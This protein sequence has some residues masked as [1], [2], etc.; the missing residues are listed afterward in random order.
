MAL[1]GEA[2]TSVSLRIPKHMPLPT[3]NNRGSDIRIRRIRP[4][5]WPAHRDLRLRALAQDPLAFGSTFERE[6]GFSDEKW[7]DLTLRGAASEQSALFVADAGR[8]GMVGM[9]AIVFVDD[10][11]HVF[12][13]WVEPRR[14]RRGLGGKLLDA[15]LDWF[16]TV[17]PDR[18]LLLEVN[19]RQEEALRLY[20]RRGFRSTGRSAPLGHAEGEKVVAMVRDVR[21]ASPGR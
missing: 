13:M 11:W 4:E 19:P 1:P 2:D 18:P 17:A 3:S 6:R 9:V 10:V 8:A 5:E 7:K 15:A 12:A 20:E 14:R 16:Q 21:P